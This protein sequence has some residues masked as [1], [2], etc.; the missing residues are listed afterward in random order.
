MIL[1]LDLDGTIFET[2][3]MDMSIFDPA[4][5]IIEEFSIRTLGGEISNEIIEE[6]KSYPFDIVANKYQFPNQLRQQFYKVIQGIDYDLAIKPYADYSALK[7]LNL[8]MY[9]VTTGISKLQKAKIEA[10]KIA[11]DFNDV[12]IDDPFEPRRKHKLGLFQEISESKDPSQFWVIG[13]NPDS[14]LKAGKDLGMNTV[15]RI[16]QNQDRSK[17]SDYSIISFNELEEI[18]LKSVRHKA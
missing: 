8:E 3:S 6:L 15:Q 12:F 17:L 5:K 7:Q 9:L 2:K 14:E 10:L 11:S 16:N 18:L 1:I 13:D 4:R